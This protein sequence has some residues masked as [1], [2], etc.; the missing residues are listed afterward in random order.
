MKITVLIP[1]FNCEQTILKTLNSVKW[2][3]QIV[4]VDSYSTDNTLK[5]IEPYK[6]NLYQKEY[7]NSAKQ[8]NWALQ[9]CDNDWV[10]QIDSDEIVPSNAEKIILEAIE[11]AKEEVHC[12]ILP[13]KNHILGK[14]VKNGGLYP[15]WQHRLIKR[16]Y[17][18]WEEKDVH[19]KVIVKGEIKKLNL[20]IIHNGMPNISKQLSNLNRYTRYEADILIRKNI[21]FSYLK[22]ILGPIYVFIKR[23]ILLGGFLDGWRGFFLAIYTAI[24]YFFSHAKFLEA[25]ILDLKTSP[26]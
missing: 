6:V 26:K 10:F 11:N 25:K 5:L 4:I 3:N 2:A 16:K 9:F 24:Y 14:W 22:M 23:Y 19:A 1:T 20:N 15:D 17:G 13:R 7:I 21:K 12:F 18:S 8:K